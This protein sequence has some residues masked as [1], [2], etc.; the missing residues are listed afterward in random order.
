MKRKTAA[1]LAVLLCAVLLSGCSSN[2]G[3]QFGEYVA[4]RHKAN[5]GRANAASA[6]PAQP[7]TVDIVTC[8]N[9]SFGP[10]L[11]FD[12]TVYPSNASLTPNKF[13]AIDGW[14]SQIEFLSS[15]NLHLVLR[16]AFTDAGYLTAT[17][18]ELHDASDTTRE[19]DGIEVRTRNAAAGCSMVTWT[20]G[21]FQFL[22]H[23][24]TN[25]GPL[26]TELVD[27]V[28]TGTRAQAV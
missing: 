20:R 13:F 15:E 5:L 24:N 2:A 28:V 19:V 26:P 18:R 27:M 23:S 1:W 10:S 14:F 21:D 4:Q 25:Q 16:T 22:L 17:Y 7:E 11:G 8:Q 3:Q 12:L 6:S 9:G